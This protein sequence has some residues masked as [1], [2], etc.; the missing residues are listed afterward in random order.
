[1]VIGLALSG[2]VVRMAETVVPRDTTLLVPFGLAAAAI[3]VLTVATW[4]ALERG[5]GSGALPHDE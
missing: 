2:V 1:M 5:F 4:R 3:L